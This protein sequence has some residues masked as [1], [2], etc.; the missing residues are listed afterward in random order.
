MKTETLFDGV[1][2][3]PSEARKVRDEVSGSQHGLEDSTQDN[4]KTHRLVARCCCRSLGIGLV[5]L[6]WT[7]I[8]W[9]VA[10]DLPSPLKTWQE[11]KQYI[12]QAVFK[13]GEMDQGIV[14]F[15]FYSLIRVAK[16]FLLGDR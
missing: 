4:G 10:P 15:A 12:L 13:G 16:G 6:I 3:D 1:T 5:L 9:K 11:S 8:S 14:R 2:F 7:A